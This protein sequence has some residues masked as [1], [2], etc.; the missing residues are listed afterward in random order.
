[1]EKLNFDEQLKRFQNILKLPKEMRWM[2]DGFTII[3]NSILI[4]KTPKELKILYI[5][6]LMFAFKKESCFPSMR[7]LAN[8]LGMKE[9][10]VQK[11]IK[12]LETIKWVKIEY[13]K[14]RP[15]IYHLVKM[16]T[17]VQG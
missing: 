8:N 15:S 5:I 4:D 1:M 14:G 11:N 17:E 3:P 7:T 2:K 9:R 13:R 6:L 12:K 16:C 10:G